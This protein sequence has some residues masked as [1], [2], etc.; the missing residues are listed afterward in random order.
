M[1]TEEENHV[2]IT[3]LSAVSHQKLLQVIQIQEIRDI[4]HILI[5]VVVT[6][7]LRALASELLEIL[8]M[9]LISPSSLGWLP[10]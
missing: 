2:T 8:K 5:E 3:C 6:E 9:R 10:F 1:L 7:I 4:G